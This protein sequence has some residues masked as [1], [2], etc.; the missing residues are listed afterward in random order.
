MAIGPRSEVGWTSEPWP[1]VLLVKLAEV[2]AAFQPYALW[3]D[4]MALL[5]GMPSMR[6]V[7][8]HGSPRRKDGTRHRELQQRCRSLILIEKPGCERQLSGS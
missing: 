1:K 5:D 3:L 6:Q 8:D 4:A 2:L 7:I